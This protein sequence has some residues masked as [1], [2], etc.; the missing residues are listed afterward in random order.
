M[1]FTHTVGTRR[2]V[3][4]DL[5]TLLARASPARVLPLSSCGAERSCLP[6]A[7]SKVLSRRKSPAASLM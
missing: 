4:A 7:Y 1:A 5:R 3:F 6:Q 2:H